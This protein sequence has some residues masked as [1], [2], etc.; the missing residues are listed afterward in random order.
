MI[1]DLK[2][3]RSNEYVNEAKSIIDILSIKN[4]AEIEC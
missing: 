1:G 3:W 4:I 2:V